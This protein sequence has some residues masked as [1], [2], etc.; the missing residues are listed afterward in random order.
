MRRSGNEKEAGGHPAR[1][2][3]VAA[4]ALIAAVPVATWWAVGDPSTDLP[5]PDYQIRPLD[6]GQTTE[7]IAGV[8]AT[9]LAAAAVVALVGAG[10]AGRFDRRWWP[11]LVELV[12]AGALCG[13]GWRV[14][15]AGVIGAN[16]GAGLVLWVG[17][18]MVAALVGWPCSTG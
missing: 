4:V 6:I 13:V 16:I 10:R 17:A 5:D 8:I 12:L 1:W 11:V 18:P 3:S 2:P 15:T 14:L 7:Q 9:V